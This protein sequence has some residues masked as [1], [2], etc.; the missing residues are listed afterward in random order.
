METYSVRVTKDYLVFCAAHFIT[1]DNQQCERLHGHNYRAAAEVTAALDK[2]CL[3]VDFVEL[4]AILREITNELDHHVLLPRENP[5]LGIEETGRDVVVTYLDR[6]RWV[7][8]AEDCVI[9]PIANS[10]AELLAHWIATRLR[11]ELDR[12]GCGP[13]EK[14]LVEIEETVGQ[15]ARYELVLGGP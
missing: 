5:I 11:N 8:P 7:F 2:N 4:K 9:L 13:V 12:R 3:V 15:S 1:Y 14:I 6:K 10:T